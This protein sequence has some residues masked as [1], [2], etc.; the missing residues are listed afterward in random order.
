MYQKLVWLGAVAY[1]PHVSLT[2]VNQ[3]VRIA[4]VANSST[5]LHSHTLLCLLLVVVTS[6]VPVEFSGICAPHYMRHPKGRN[7]G[8]LAEHL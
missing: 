1:P 8:Y 5:I 4:T 6:Q 7:H 3:S 2:V